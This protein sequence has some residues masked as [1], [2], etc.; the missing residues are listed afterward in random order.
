MC[1]FYVNVSHSGIASIINTF[2]AQQNSNFCFFKFN[3]LNLLKIVIE[4]RKFM[5]LNFSG[6]AMIRK[7]ISFVNLTLFT[8]IRL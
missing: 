4:Q 7:L 1:F 5:F 6:Y 8:V 3:T 2:H